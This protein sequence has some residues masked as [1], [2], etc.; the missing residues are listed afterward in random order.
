MAT[1]DK[2]HLESF[3]SHM[4]IGDGE[5]VIVDRQGK[6]V[7]LASTEESVTLSDGEGNEIVL[8]DQL[9]SHIL[10]VPQA[11]V[12]RYL[13]KVGEAA[14]MERAASGGDLWASLWDVDGS[15]SV[16]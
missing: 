2:D 3:C 5:V 1:F 12:E 4:F 6:E 10:I 8:D 16:R 13:K 9:W 14:R 11:A 7:R 15:S